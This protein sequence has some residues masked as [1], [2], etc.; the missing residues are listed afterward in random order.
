MAADHGDAVESLY[1]QVDDGKGGKRPR[2][3]RSGNPLSHGAGYLAT[4][5]KDDK[6]SGLEPACHDNFLALT[7]IR[8]NAA[9]LLNKDLYLGRRIP[10]IGTASLRNYLCLATEWF[11]LDLAAYNNILQELDKSYVRRKKV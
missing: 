2:T 3:N 10:E 11:Q 4:K 7:E 1:K 8:D 9:H 6:D 5:L